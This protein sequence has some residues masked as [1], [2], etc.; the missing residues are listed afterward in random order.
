MREQ[1][2]A[3]VIA[4]RN[5]ERTIGS[6]V[7]SALHSNLVTEVIVVSDGSTD[8]TAQ[9]AATAARGDGR[10]RVLTLR[11]NVGPAEAR[12]RGIGV[13]KADS[14]A[15]L[16]A[17]D[18]FLPGRLEGLVAGRNWDLIADNVVFV[19]DPSRPPPTSIL[20]IGSSPAF[21]PLSLAEFVQGNVSQPG[22]TRSEYGFLKPVI[23]RSFLLRTGLRYDHRLRLGEDY[24]LYVRALMAG[25][26]FL[27]TRDVGYLA[28]VRAES[29]SSRH[30]TADLRAF[31]EA[32]RAHIRTDGFTDADRRSMRAVLKGVERRHAIRSVLD[33]KAKKGLIGAAGTLITR[34]HWISSVTSIVLKDKLPKGWMRTQMEDHYR[35]LLP[36][37]GSR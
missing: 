12:N 31:A 29:L 25:G 14:I 27:L 22:R 20:G 33:A 3:V 10:L 32:I 18:E 24:D 36:M 21:E 8:K 16:D 26:R 13:A 6:A 37:R 34:P 23:S 15:L 17:D 5:A 35:L 11:E 1:T 7:R 9:A 4:A 2:I 30:G 19:S 28:H